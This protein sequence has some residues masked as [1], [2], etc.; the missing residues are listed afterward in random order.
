MAWLQHEL[1]ELVK[2]E[3]AASVACL[4]HEL[5]ELAKLAFFVA[6]VAWP[7]HELDELAKI[8]IA[9]SVAFLQHEL[10]KMELLA[11]L[12]AVFVL[13]PFGGFCRDN[14]LG[15][16]PSFA[17]ATRQEKT[18]KNALIPFHSEYDYIS[19]APPSMGIMLQNACP[20]QPPQ[21]I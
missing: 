2:I 16:P 4:Q 7:E 8:E 21:P 11:L 19:R 17:D 14:P 15:S 12:L 6:S 20:P 1:D 5:D 18:R 10:A 3:I 13:A 9:A